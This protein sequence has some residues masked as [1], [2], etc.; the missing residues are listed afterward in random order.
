[1]VGQALEIATLPTP[2]PS[3]QASSPRDVAKAGLRRFS[4]A[5]FRE[6]ASPLVEEALLGA[7][8]EPSAARERELAT[9]A[10]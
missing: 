1:M 5:E 2:A 6:P 3:A 10:R 8:R 9:E 7:A 4:P